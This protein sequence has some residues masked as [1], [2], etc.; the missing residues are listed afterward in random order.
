MAD[1]RLP[2]DNDGSEGQ[3]LPDEV[4]DTLPKHVKDAIKRGD[5]IPLRLSPKDIQR[6]KKLMAGMLN[7]ATYLLDMIQY[8]VDRAK[9]L[10][11]VVSDLVLNDTVRFYTSDGVRLNSATEIIDYMDKAK[12]S[13]VDRLKRIMSMIPPG[14]DKEEK[15]VFVTLAAAYV[16]KRGGD[17]HLITV[18]H[19]DP[20]RLDEAMEIIVTHRLFLFVPFMRWLLNPMF[21]RIWLNSIASEAV[22]IQK[23][24]NTLVQEGILA[25]S[26]KKPKRDRPPKDGPTDKKRGPKR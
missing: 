19:G 22:A 12:D 7:P 5:V 9:A 24:R 26:K 14:S 16:M 23:V 4:L 25:G 1:R 8:E 13:C 11:N 17:F 18:F 21:V 10:Q 6:Y 15:K 2:L 20:K 3:Q